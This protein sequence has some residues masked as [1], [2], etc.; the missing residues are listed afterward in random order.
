MGAMDQDE[1]RDGT[2]KW[3]LMT[4]DQV[5]ARVK[6]VFEQYGEEVVSSVELYAVNPRRM[7][8]ILGRLGVDAPGNFT[9]QL[10]A[11]LNYAQQEGAD[12]LHRR[13]RYEEWKALQTDSG[14]H[15]TVSDIFRALEDKA[16]KDT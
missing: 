15:T 16:K 12:R 7:R 2:A 8:Y 9:D 1:A 6:E 5:K 13:L 4:E 3:G 11:L 14:A 10:T